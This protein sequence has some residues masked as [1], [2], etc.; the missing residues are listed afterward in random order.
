MEGNVEYLGKITFGASL[1][2]PA[3]LFGCN[4][5]GGQFWTTP[6]QKCLRKE[7]K[8]P[9]CEFKKEDVYV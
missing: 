5:C 8:C 9:M 7:V 6:M 3:D 2:M 1:N 4:E